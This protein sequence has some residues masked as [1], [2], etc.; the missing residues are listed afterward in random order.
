MD[1]LKIICISVIVSVL[2][3]GGYAMLAKPAAAPSDNK[4]GALAGPDIASPYLNWG[5]VRI[6]NAS[7][8][9]TAAAST[10]MRGFRCRQSTN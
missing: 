7:A 1:I 6:Y 4:S 3:V 5:G 9:L 10:T 8:G 2:A